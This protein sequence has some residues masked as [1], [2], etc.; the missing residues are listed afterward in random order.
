MR[1]VIGKHTEVK[2]A[3]KFIRQGE[4]AEDY[5]YKYEVVFTLPKLTEE[6]LKKFLDD[7]IFCVFIPKKSHN[8]IWEQFRT[9]MKEIKKKAK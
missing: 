3:I 2:M 7:P 6:A 9:Q 8:I 1:E 5:K 4:N